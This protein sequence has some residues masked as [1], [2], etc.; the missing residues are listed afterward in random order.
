MC[1]KIYS[2]FATLFAIIKNFFFCM[3]YPFWRARNS[4]G[5]KSLDYSWTE[6]DV[7]PEG[8]QKSFGKQL[9]KDLRKVLIKEKCLHSFY[10]VD[11]KEK[12]GSLRLSGI[13]TT[14]KIDE[15]IEYYELLSRCYCLFC[16]KPVRYISN[17]WINYLC[18]D[19][20]KE[21]IPPEY[22]EKCKVTYQDIPKYYDE[23]TQKFVSQKKTLPIDF[24]E[25]WGLK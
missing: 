3:R 9:S 4:F 16:G 5:K 17:G 14:D 20:A 6:Y 12:W 13:F 11:I 7:I 25:K 8:W 23:K 15:V 2:F 10:F 19:C 22:L 24:E 18:E 21:H 1:L